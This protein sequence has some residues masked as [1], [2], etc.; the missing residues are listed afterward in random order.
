MLWTHSTNTHWH[1]TSVQVP[2]HI[3]KWPLQCLIV[4]IVPTIKHTHVRKIIM[5]VY[6][7]KIS[8]TW[9]KKSL[10]NESMNIWKSPHVTCSWHRMSWHNALCKVTINDLPPLNK[11]VSFGRE[12]G[13][14]VNRNPWKHNPNCS[15]QIY[16]C[17]KL[18]LQG[19]T[20]LTASV[21]TST[22]FKQS[23]HVSFCHSTLTRN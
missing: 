19:A 17:S 5:S 4:Q 15:N 21:H 1:L 2:K 13:V 18:P 3:I 23:K 12:R 10:I 7:I 11:V 9:K 6:A 8:V 16:A 14:K 22:H 20:P